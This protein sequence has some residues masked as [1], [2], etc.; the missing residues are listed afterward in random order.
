[1]HVSPDWTAGTVWNHACVETAVDFYTY[2]TFL[3]SSAPLSINVAK[4]ADYSLFTAVAMIPSS[5]KNKILYAWTETVSIVWTKHSISNVL[6]NFLQCELWSLLQTSHAYLTAEGANQ[7]AR[8][9]G[10]E[11]VPQESLI[12]EY[13]RMRWRKNLAPDA[14]PVECQMWDTTVLSLLAL[15]IFIF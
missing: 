8:S 4:G 12:T 11:E 6:C 1:M 13:S 9:M 10:I 3:P 5:D 14:N 7:F 15:F 2:R